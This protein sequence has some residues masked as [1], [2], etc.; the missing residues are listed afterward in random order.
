MAKTKQVKEQMVGDIA[1]RL[2]KATSVVFTNFDGL[3]V[4]ET[5]EL[6]TLLRELAIDYSVIKK[7]LFKLS[8]KKGKH[9]VANFD[10]MTGSLGAAFGYGDEV[11]PAKTL[12]TFTKKH[13]TLKLVGGIYQGSFIDAR[14]VMQLADLPSKMELLTKLAWLMNY[15]MSGFVNALA[16]SMRNFVYALK[17]ISE[18]KPS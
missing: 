2:A 17:A 15:P 14:S 18:K 9:D 3:N 12:K 11:L 8:L 7:T 5:T 6:R 10:L 4:Q 1:D 13:P 16:G